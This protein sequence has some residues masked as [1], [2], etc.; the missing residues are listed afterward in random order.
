MRSLR[1][2]VAKCS[3]ERGRRSFLANLGGR[4]GLRRVHLVQPRGRRPFGPAVQRGSSGWPGPGSGGPC[5]C[6][7]TRRAC[8]STRTC[9]PPSRT[10]STT[11][12][13]RAAGLP[14]GGRV[15]LGEPGDRALGRPQTVRDASCR[16]SP[17]ARG[18]GTGGRRFRG[19]PTRCPRRCEAFGGEPR[20]LDLR[21]AR[22]RTSSTCVT[23]GSATRWRIS[24][25]RSTASRRTS[26][27]A[28]TSGDIAAD[29]TRA[30]CGGGP[31]FFAVTA[32]V[33]TTFTVSNA[34]QANEQADNT[35]Q[36]AG[37][38]R[39]AEESARRRA[40]EA[41]QARSA[42]AAATRQAHASEDEAQ[43]AALTAQTAEEAA[44]DER[45]R[46]QAAEASTEDEA[47]KA[48]QAETARARG[49]QSATRGS[50]R[51]P[52]PR[53]GANASASEAEV[54]ARKAEDSAR[55]GLAHRRRIWRGSRPISNSWPS[56]MHATRPLARG[57]GRS[58]AAPCCPSVWTAPISRCCW[59]SRAGTRHRR[60]TA[61]SLMRP[62]VTRS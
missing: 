21:W 36:S 5:G 17:T 49:G 31:P 20:H 43:Q 57:P 14:G 30:S 25:R 50:K 8:R 60:V 19:E 28:R 32:A 56:T 12:V 58:Q 24:P 2:Q 15:A 11:R 51:R 41:E 35:R 52:I 29:A 45:D 40:R 42:E 44:A 61:L 26:S 33:A 53:S 7:A 46:A 59:R 54:A 34:A 38:A 39:T 10:R 1:E 9:G 48:R 13:L 22:T 16:W 18:R 37:H 62:L 47:T 3:R 4:H 55:S 27:R 6:S 23:A